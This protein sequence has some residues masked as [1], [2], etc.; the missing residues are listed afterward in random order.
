L[1]KHQDGPRDAFAFRSSRGQWES[2][3]ISGALPPFFGEKIKKGEIAH[4]SLGE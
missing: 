3:D 1:K 2:Q 4:G